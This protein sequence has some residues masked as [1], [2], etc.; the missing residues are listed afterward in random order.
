VGAGTVS[1]SFHA[2][3]S[4]RVF[5]LGQHR[6]GRLDNRGQLFNFT[7]SGVYDIHQV[8]VC[9]CVCVCV[10]HSDE[11]ELTAF[12]APWYQDTQKRETSH[13][14]YS[15]LLNSRT[16]SLPSTQGTDIVLPFYQSSAGYGFLWNLASF[17]AVDLRPNDTIIWSSS[18]SALVDIWVTVAPP[19][20]AHP[21]HSL[22]QHFAHATGHPPRACALSP[23][24]F[25]PQ[26]FGRVLCRLPAV[27]PSANCR[28]RALGAGGG[29]AA[30]PHWATGLWHSRNRYRSQAELLD[31]ARHYRHLNITLSVIAI[32][33]L[34]W[35]DEP[36]FDSP[37]ARARKPHGT[38]AGG[39]WRVLTGG[40]VL[41]LS[42]S[43]THT[44]HSSDLFTLP[45]LSAQAALWRLCVR[46][47][48]LAGPAGDGGRATHDGRAANGE[49][50]AV[51]AGGAH[52]K[53]R[54][55]LLGR[56]VA[57]LRRH[58]GPRHADA[59]LGHG[60]AGA[61]V[62]Q[63]AVGGRQLTVHVCHGACPFSD[64]GW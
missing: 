47:G 7:E 60:P 3:S 13:R 45:S 31:A 43:H 19:D 12:V 20:D 39:G 17:G 24:R 2:P 5:G 41:S 35:C 58:E 56:R 14:L 29:V 16:V 21:F 36:L 27:S 63:P 26:N 34:H 37:H 1:M 30:M 18:G 59:R 42:L 10:L 62:R 52:V 15:L 38:A 9:V 4:E 48:M 54:V 28:R 25:L 32:D 8:C 23:T 22:M 51:R 57:Q 33:F 49:R 40:I 11:S 44:H 53:S 61:G 6:T 55:Q 46:P 50:V 64:C